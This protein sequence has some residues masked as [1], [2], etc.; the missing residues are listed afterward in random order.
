[1]S[2]YNTVFSFR[3]KPIKLK[4][5]ESHRFLFTMS[6]LRKYLIRKRNLF[7][8]VIL[9]FA[10][11]YTKKLTG[12][13]VHVYE[14]TFQHCYLLYQITPRIRAHK[15]QCHVS[16]IFPQF[17]FREMSISYPCLKTHANKDFF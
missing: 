10:R 5:S 13:L 2:R 3:Q 8:T 1:M 9:L 16:P 17:F 11:K 4:K 7:T 6:C 15:S 14:L 12:S